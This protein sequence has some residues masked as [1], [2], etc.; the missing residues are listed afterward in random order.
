MFMACLLYYVL[1]RIKRGIAYC[2]IVLTCKML[3]DYTVRGQ[4][5]TFSIVL[6]RCTATNN[7]MFFMVLSMSTID[8]D[9]NSAVV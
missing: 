9:C 4:I 1:K 2:L 8:T 5:I 7:W 3:T 6:V